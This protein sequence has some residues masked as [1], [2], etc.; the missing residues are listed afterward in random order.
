MQSLPYRHCFPTTLLLVLLTN[1]FAGQ[2]SAQVGIN[3]DNSAPDTSAILDVKSS[4]KGILIPR[5]TTNQRDAITSPAT[6]L[7][8]FNL[9]DNCTDIYNG[10]SWM[11]DCPLVVSPDS[12]VVGGTWRLVSNS[13]NESER[14]VSFT[15][16]GKVYTGLGCN[17]INGVCSNAFFEFNPLT[18]DFLPIADFPGAG[19]ER[20]VAF[21]INGKGYVGTGT[22]NNGLS[23]DFYEYDPVANSWTRRADFPGSLRFNAVGFV[24]GGKGY[25]GTGF[26]FGGDRKKMDFYAYDPITDQWAAIAPIPVATA[27]AFSFVINGKGYVGA[28]EGG[29]DFYEY[30]PTTN[31]W[32][33]KADYPIQVQDAASFSLFG[34]GYA[35]TGF[36]SNGFSKSFYEYNPTTDRW[37]RRADVI[38][39]PRTAA[40]GFSV[41]GKGYIV[42]GTP[43]PAFSSISEYTVSKRPTYSAITPDDSFV[44]PNAAIFDGDNDTKIQVETS[45]DD[46]AIR[47]DVAGAPVAI[48]DS[49]GQVGIGTMRPM[50]QL[51]VVGN[52]AASGGVTASSFSGDGSLLTGVP[53]DNLGSHLATTNLQLGSNWLSGDGDNEGL[54]ID[55]TGKVGIGTS[56][57]NS[58]LAVNGDIAIAKAA[59][60][61]GLFTEDPDDNLENAILNMSVNTFFQNRLN[62]SIGGLFRIDSRSGTDTPL[63]QW[64]VKPRGQANPLVN[65]ILMTLTENGNLGIGSL[66]P[67]RAKVEILGSLSSDI[68]PYGFLGSNGGIGTR[69][70]VGAYSLYANQR[71][72]ASEFNAHSDERIK[73]IYGRSDSRADLRTLLDIQITDYRHI[74]TLLKGSGLHKK[75]IAQQV[76]EVYPQAVH[77]G[78]REVIPDIYQKTIHRAGWIQLATDLV[79]GERV[80]LITEHSSQLYTV[81][82]VEPTRFRVAGLAAPTTEATAIFVYG[83]EVDDFHTVDYEAISMLNVSATQELAR[84]IERLSQENN[85][86]RVRNQ[87]FENRLGKLEATLGSHFSEATNK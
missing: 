1:I 53:G 78:I 45:D 60:P 8:V 16:N 38:G 67:T 26:V 44:L 30:D 70:T 32:T 17:D 47:F 59:L 25:L 7:T 2:L 15:I 27:F 43:G 36:A 82:Q 68:G 80:K 76:V 64:L 42:F 3:T 48:I 65:N 71:I 69:A 61:T 21:S 11:K 75:V 57:L 35:G 37:V 56:N 77:K 39:P 86:L 29:K 23:R 18:G 85:R 55:A 40:S 28:G 73:Q 19:R 12:Q 31:S 87:Q 66:H 83:R 52:I 49:A 34:R 74:D 5:M 54:F 41:G 6:G 81:T 63:F 79:V 33:R 84:Q 9:D 51:E 22:S 14:G 10:A 13:N 4:T 62:D 24:I 58:A 20:A 50:A 46:D 72:A